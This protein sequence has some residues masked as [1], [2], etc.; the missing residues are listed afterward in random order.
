MKN[1]ELKLSIEKLGQA[2]NRLEEGLAMVEDDLDRDGVIQRFE[3]TFE[4][5]WKTLKRILLFEG[6]EC[7]S[8]RSCIK[9]AFRSGILVEGELFVDMLEDRNRLSHLYNDRKSREVF[10]RIKFNYVNSLRKNFPTIE[11]YSDSE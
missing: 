11:T 6:I 9:E 4:L 3:F 8:P 5:Y 7:N 2:L 10:E 1:E